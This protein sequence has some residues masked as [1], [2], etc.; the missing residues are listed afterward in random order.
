[1]NF[2]VDID[3]CEDFWVGEGG[4]GLTVLSTPVQMFSVTKCDYWSFCQFRYGLAVDRNSATC[5]YHHIQSC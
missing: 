1:M 2:C 5:L 3:M 4:G